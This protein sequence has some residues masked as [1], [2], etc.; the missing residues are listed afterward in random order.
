[1]QIHI[2]KIA[3]NRENLWIAQ[4]FFVCP[5]RGRMKA[6]VMGNGVIR[7]ALTFEEQSCAKPSDHRHICVQ[8]PCDQLTRSTF[9]KLYGSIPAPEC[10]CDGV[11]AW[12]DALMSWRLEPPRPFHASEVN[13]QI[14]RTMMAKFLLAGMP[15]LALP[16]NAFASS[17]L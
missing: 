4:T 16:L 17:D 10:E 12:R 14:R 8:G 1:M 5:Y 11:L 2:R 3:E 13:D 15:K 7:F 9:S 6:E